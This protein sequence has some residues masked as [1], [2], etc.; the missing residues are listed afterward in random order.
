MVDNT[1]KRI[2][3]RATTRSENFWMQNLLSRWLGK[4]W[5]RPYP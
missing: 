1:A 4:Q 5:L 3:A 2:S